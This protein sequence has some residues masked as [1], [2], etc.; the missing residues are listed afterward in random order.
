MFDKVLNMP[1]DSVVRCL[2][3]QSFVDRSFF[4]EA[5]V[6]QYESSGKF[7]FLVKLNVPTPES[8]NVRF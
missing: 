4:T 2:W 1:M 8:C 5:E 3:I 6:L 7:P